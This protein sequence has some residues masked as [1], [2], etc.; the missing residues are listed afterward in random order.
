MKNAVAAIV[1]G[2]GPAGLAAAK[3]LKDI[4]VDPVIVEMEQN[5]G[6]VWRKHYDRLHLHT[7]RDL[8]ALPGLAIPRAA[9][10]YPTREDVV[11]YFDSYAATFNLKPKFAEKVLAI[12]PQGK[13]WQVTTSRNTYQSPI[14]IVGTGWASFPN[15]PA[16]LGEKTFRGEIIHS[17][18]Y[19][20][21]L[22]YKGKRVL[23]VGFGN[24]GAEIALDLAENGVAVGLSVRSP[25]NI[26]PRE[27]FGISVLRFAIA[28][29]FLPPKFADILNAPLIRFFLGTPESYGLVKSPKG[30]LQT[31]HEDGKIPVLDVGT[32]EIIKRGKISIYGGLDRL[33]TN[34]VEFADGRKAPFDCIILATGFSPNMP[35]L[36]PDSP[37]L[38]DAKGQPNLSDGPA[39]APG[40]YFLG[41]KPVATGELR[42]LARGAIRIAA[43]IKA[44]N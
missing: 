25:V 22:P 31:I 10:S 23:V 32:C 17:T 44:A 13:Q 38:F 6:A 19:K 34:E 12:K 29:R 36:F 28:Q 4:G 3:C 43:N 1:I 27:L 42:E 40:L 16:L 5:V 14:V 26:I 20:N 39:A 21:A 2:A 8:S 11:T 24:S 18:A 30:A 15:R 33:N 41:A 9:G 7:P 35:S 37:H